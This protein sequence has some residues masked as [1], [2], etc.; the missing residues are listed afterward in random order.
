MP[1]ASDD[2]NSQPAVE[3]LERVPTA[4]V[5]LVLRESDPADDLA[6]RQDRVVHDL[7]S[8]LQVGRR[9]AAVAA[10]AGQLTRRGLAIA[11]A[12]PD[13]RCVQL[14]GEGGGTRPLP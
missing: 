9:Y 2:C 1:T 10:L 14:D 6:L 3:R 7:G 12:H 8:E 5:I 4:A 13:V 11:R